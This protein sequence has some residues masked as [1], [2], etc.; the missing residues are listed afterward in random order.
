MLTNGQTGMKNLCNFY[1]TFVQILCCLCATTIKKLYLK[2]NLLTSFT[3]PLALICRKSCPPFLLRTA[4]CRY[5][6]TEKD[7][8]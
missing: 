4:H 8:Q 1:D 7:G 6:K 2:K 5:K 3:K